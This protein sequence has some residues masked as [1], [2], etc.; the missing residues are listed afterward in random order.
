MQG[1]VYK[2]WFRLEGTWWSPLPQALLRSRCLGFGPLKPRISRDE[3]PTTVL[4]AWW[5]VQPPS[6]QGIFFLRFNWDF[7]YYN[8]CVPSP[9]VTDHIRENSFSCSLWAPI[10]CW[11]GHLDPPLLPPRWTNRALT[12]S[13]HTQYI[14][15]W[16]CWSSA[17]STAR[18][19]RA[20]QET[21]WYLKTQAK[22][23]PNKRRKFEGIC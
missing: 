2:D 7:L 16:K 6:L 18:M 21:T 15:Q 20:S 5:S 1:C 19:S 3:G 14:H 4:N 9:P 10:R 8:I 23:H 22:G 13:S 17:S 12:D 11:E